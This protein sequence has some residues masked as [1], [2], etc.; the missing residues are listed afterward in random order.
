M[1]APRAYAVAAAIVLLAV[2]I[3]YERPWEPHI[4]SGTLER[5]LMHTLEHARSVSCHRA[6]NDGSIPIDD[7][8]Y[9]CDIDI[10]D[11]VPAVWWVGT[12]WHRITET[13]SGA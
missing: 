2:L 10:S 1:T 4:S 5:E 6:R 12:D 8:D 13:T 9:E 3:W 7:V 11:D